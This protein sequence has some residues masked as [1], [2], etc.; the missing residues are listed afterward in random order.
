MS[1]FLH[2]HHSLS[3]SD[4]EYFFNLV[5]W[6]EILLNCVCAWVSKWG[7]ER[8]RERNHARACSHIRLFRQSFDSSW[9]HWMVLN[10]TVSSSSSS[11][12]SSL[13]LMSFAS[14]FA[15]SHFISFAFWE[16]KPF[17]VAA[18][19]LV[20]IKTSTNTHLHTAAEQHRN[21]AFPY[22]HTVWLRKLVQNGFSC[23]CACAW[24]D[25][26]T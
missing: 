26:Y 13:C 23:L 17:V 18:V 19:V 12:L 2:H 4:I 7:R 22:T 8:K 25:T 3:R 15:L 11:F 6:T 1:R 20:K 10:Q 14:I 16:V 9:K 24:S 5:Y 21:A